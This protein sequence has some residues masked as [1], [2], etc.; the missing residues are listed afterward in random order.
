MKESQAHGNMQ[1][2]WPLPSHKLEN[3][4]QSEIGNPE[5]GTE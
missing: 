3:V 2:D 1:Q 4:L 5:G